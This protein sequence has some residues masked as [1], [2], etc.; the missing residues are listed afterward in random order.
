MVIAVSSSTDSS[1]WAN[2]IANKASLEQ[3]TIALSIYRQAERVSAPKA[4]TGKVNNN[5]QKRERQENPFNSYD[6]NPFAAAN[7]N[8]LESIANRHFLSLTR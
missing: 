2:Q 8:P 5:Q 7:V 6:T 4:N 3:N 1:I